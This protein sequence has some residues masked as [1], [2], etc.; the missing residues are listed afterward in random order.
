MVISVPL[1]FFSRHRPFHGKK[2]Y[3]M[4]LCV[5]AKFFWIFYNP[6][7][8]VSPVEVTFQHILEK[9]SGIIIEI[10]SRNIF[11]HMRTAPKNNDILQRIAFI[12]LSIHFLIFCFPIGKIKNITVS[13]TYYA[14]N[15]VIGFF[16]I[17]ICN[18]N[19]IGLVCYLLCQH[20]RN[21]SS[22]DF[23]IPALSRIPVQ[24][25]YNLLRYMIFVYKLNN[26]AGTSHTAYF[27]ICQYISICKFF[28]HCYSSNNPCALAYFQ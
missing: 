16:E 19:Q 5:T 15:N 6:N 21:V 17:I 25:L 13:I 8:S 11:C 14:I 9:S 1:L 7:K 24:N 2:F 22:V 23:P 3:I 18:N 28:K 12:L 10:H 26:I 27:L 20:H 4:Y